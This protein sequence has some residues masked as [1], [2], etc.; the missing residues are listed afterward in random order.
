MDYIITPDKT[1]GI[2]NIPLPKSHTL[3]SILFASLTKDNSIIKYYLENSP[4]TATMINAC[5]ALGAKIEI[6]A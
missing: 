2:T 3:R 4:D 5:R 1:K 6:L